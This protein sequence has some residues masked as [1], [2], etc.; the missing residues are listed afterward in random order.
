MKKS[1]KNGQNRGSILIITVIISTVLFTVGVIF[2]S[3]I[4]KEIE[5]QSYSKR[6]QLAFGIADSAWECVL[7][8]D[9]HTAAFAIA[10]EVGNQRR[11]LFSCNESFFSREKELIACEIEER[12]GEKKWK[13]LGYSRPRQYTLNQ[14]NA[15]SGGK[16]HEFVIVRDDR[17]I[18]SDALKEG[19][20]PC[21]KVIVKKSCL[22][23]DIGENCTT[24]SSITTEIEVVGYDGCEVTTDETFKPGEIRRL[25]E[26][27]Y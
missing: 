9:L 8:N 7:Y 14:I 18:C 23:K 1:L 15:T 17:G 20:P 24:D 22:Q 5:R 2:L 26:I 16:K 10:G 12:N 6:S 11:G 13:K 19:K 3:I 4:N 25:L 21:A 27:R